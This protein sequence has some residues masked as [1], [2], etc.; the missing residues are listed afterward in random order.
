MSEEIPKS[1]PVDPVYL[2]IRTDEKYEE[3]RNEVQEIGQRE[4][5]LQAHVAKV[6][7]RVEKSISYGTHKNTERI[8]D[9]DVRLTTAENSIS[10]FNNQINNPET[11]LFAQNKEIKDLIGEIR[12]GFIA[13]VFSGLIVAIILWGIK[14]I[15]F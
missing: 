1:K 5:D 13:V 9:L 11:G 14:N 10:Q 3:V 4:R 2:F 6:E 12:R 7:E 8:G 15:H